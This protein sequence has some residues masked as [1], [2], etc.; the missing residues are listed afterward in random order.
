MDVLEHQTVPEGGMRIKERKGR[1]KT[2][3]QEIDLGGLLVNTAAPS[4]F[5]MAF[6][7]PTGP[8]ETKPQASRKYG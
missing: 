6:L 8:W 3:K 4:S 1:K 2:Q 7:Y 5:G